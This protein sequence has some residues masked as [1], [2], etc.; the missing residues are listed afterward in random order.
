MRRRG[1]ALKIRRGMIL[2]AVIVF[3]AAAFLPAA[4]FFYPL[5]YEGLILEQAKRYELDPALLA[6]IVYEESKFSPM[7]R[8]P[9]GAV[10]LMQLMPETASWASA[11]IGRPHLAAR[12]T[13]PA[14]NLA[15]GSWYFHYLL[16]RYRNTAFA[17]AAYN[18]G[19]RN[20][21]KWLAQ[22][23][24][25]TQNQVIDRIPFAET[26]AFVRRAQRSRWIYRWLYPELKQGHGL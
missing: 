3:L 12:L 24:G 10:G 18:G 26:R 21:D 25:R 8:S 17:L 14:A 16:A 11:E 2:A 15:I 9:A 7:S 5:G 4:R 6:A 22:N 13:E 20:L 19:Q 1:P 23:N